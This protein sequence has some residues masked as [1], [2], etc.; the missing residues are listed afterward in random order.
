MN[1]VCK[2]LDDRKRFV[3]YVYHLSRMQ[4]I[5]KNQKDFAEKISVSPA[6]LS[7]AL[8]GDTRYLT[9]SLEI[10]VRYFVNEAGLGDLVDREEKTQQDAELRAS[11]A[12]GIFIPEE[13][14]AMFENMT[15]TIRIQAQMLAR[16]QGGAVLG[17]A[18]PASPKNFRTDTLK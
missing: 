4:G 14:R 1:E 12:P 17:G 10:K 3:A 18:Y 6:T 13:T 16:L 5:V 15:E 7:L 8:N 11:Q 2:N 9:S